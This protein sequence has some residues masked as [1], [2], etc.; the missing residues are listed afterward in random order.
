MKSVAAS[1][2]TVWDSTVIATKFHFPISVSSYSGDFV[3]N[4][5]DL[6]DK[7]VKEEYEHLTAP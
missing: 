7:K 2:T 1:T 5:W 3:R 6:V 4:N